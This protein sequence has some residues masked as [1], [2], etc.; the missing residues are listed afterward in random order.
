MEASSCSNK[1]CCHYTVHPQTITFLAH[2]KYVAKVEG[3]HLVVVPLSVLPSWIRWDVLQLTSVR[4]CC[5]CGVGGVAACAGLESVSQ[6]QS[7]RVESR[8][9]TPIHCHTF[10]PDQR[11]QALVPHHAR[12]AAALHR[13]GGAQEAGPGGERRHHALAID[14]LHVRLLV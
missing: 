3:P 11:V 9:S 7:L 4:R 12:S 8:T 10:P 13:P 6:G 5:M 2:L 1:A 14:P